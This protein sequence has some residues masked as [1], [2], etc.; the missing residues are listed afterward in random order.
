MVSTI[1][2]KQTLFLATG[3]WLRLHPPG[4]AIS[5]QEVKQLGSSIGST[6]EPQDMHSVRIN[7]VFVLRRLILYKIY[8]LFLCRNKQNCKL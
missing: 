5:R 8:E 4:Y 6:L 3:L 7:R 1:E 2:Y